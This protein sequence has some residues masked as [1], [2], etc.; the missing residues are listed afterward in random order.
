MR[1]ILSFDFLNQFV[2]VGY[3]YVCVHTHV[4]LTEKLDQFNKTKII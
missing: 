3:L 4:L 2:R 1:L